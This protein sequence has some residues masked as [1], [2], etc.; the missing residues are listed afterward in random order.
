MGRLE[1]RRRCLAAACL[2]VGA[3]CAAAS[4]PLVPS[5]IDAEG[6]GW[7][8]AAMEALWRDGAVVLSRLHEGFDDSEGKNTSVN[9]QDLA[10][11]LPAR[12][13]AGAGPGAPVLLSPTA[14][15]NSVHEEL[16]EAKRRGLYL[17]G[18]G[19]L[20]HTD[21]YVYGDD[22]PDFVFLLCEQASPNG[23][24]NAL[25]DGKA[26]LASL[27]AGGEAQHRLAAWLAATPVDLSEPS[28]TGIAMG[29]HAEGPVVQQQRTASGRTRLKWRRQINVR[30][31]Q[32][33]A[34]WQ[35]LASAVGGAD[36][37]GASEEANASGC[38]AKEPLGDRYLSLWR[39]LPSMDEAAAAEA[40]A[41]LH[42]LDRLL[43]VVGDEA[44]AVHSFALSRGEALVVDNYRV[45]H[46][47]APYWP[48][49]VGEASSAAAAGPERRLWRVWSWTSEGSGLPPDGARTSH[50]LNA[51]VFKGSE[52]TDHKR[53]TT[54]DL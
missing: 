40:T 7:A 43:Q 18:S 22:M 53:P 19:L 52:I 54:S 16:L 13:F 17:P 6:D 32:R 46:G 49:A 36:T 38:P 15:V 41:Q 9:F 51:E 37:C 42:E 50:P 35:P 1:R 45:L 24:R 48:G 47:R 21:G 34:N 39:A 8:Q 14:P 23:G 4:G 25:L 10:G 11:T 2:A 31:A 26:F 28:E 3:R 30:E 44:F 20:P 33:L 12:L 27:E 29:R 5:R